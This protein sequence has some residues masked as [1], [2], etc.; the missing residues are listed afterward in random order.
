MVRSRTALTRWL[1][2]LTLTHACIQPGIVSAGTKALEAK[3]SGNMII[4]ETPCTAEALLIRQ[5]ISAKI[6]DSAKLHTMISSA[7]ATTPK[8]SGRQPMMRPMITVRTVATK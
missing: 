8:A 4:I 5:P 2:G 1:T 3:V 7:D 6:Q